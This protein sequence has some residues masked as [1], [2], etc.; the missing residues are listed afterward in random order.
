MTKRDISEWVRDVKSGL[1]PAKYAYI[2]ETYEIGQRLDKEKPQWEITDKKFEVDGRLV[3]EVKAGKDRFL[4]Y[5][6]SGKGAPE[7]K[8]KGQFVP[9]IGFAKNGWF[10]KGRPEGKGLKDYDPWYN[11]KTFKEIAKHLEKNKEKIFYKKP[12]FKSVEKVLKRRIPTYK[13]IEKPKVISRAS[14]IIKRESGD[15]LGISNTLKNIISKP[16]ETLH[17]K[18][19]LK[20]ER[21]EEYNRKGHFKCE[22][23]GQIFPSYAEAVKHWNKVHYNV[24]EHI[25]T[26]TKEVIGKKIPALLPENIRRSI[27]TPV[28]TGVKR[29]VA[30]AGK[31]YSAGWQRAKEGPI[32]GDRTNWICPSCGKS[33][34]FR[35]KVCANNQCP[36]YLERIQYFKSI[37]QD[38]ANVDVRLKRQLNPYQTTEY[39]AE[40]DMERK[41]LSTSARER[42]DTE[43]YVVIMFVIAGIAA[44]F[45][46]P[47]L[48]FPYQL[49]YL[50]AALMGAMPI[51]ILLPDEADILNSLGWNRKGETYEMIEMGARGWLLVPKAL[52]KIVFFGLVIYQFFLIN[53]II[54][55]VIAFIFYFSLDIEFRNSEPYKM[56]ESFFRMVLGGFIAYLFLVAFGTISVGPS[57]AAMAVAFFAT[58][59]VYKKEKEEAKWRISVEITDKFKTAGGYFDK[60]DRFV[61]FPIWMLVALIYSGVLFWTGD[62]TQIMFGLIW[63]VSLIAGM[64]S[65][66]GGRPALGVVMVIVALFAFSS[67]Y[68][69]Q[70][71]QAVFGYYWPQVQSFSETVLGPVEE[72]FYQAQAGMS[73]AWLMLSNPQQYY[74]LQQQ[75]QQA[76]KSVVKSGGTIRSIE[77]SK[78][79]L[80]TTATG[81][82]EPQ[83]DPL[84]GSIELHNEG[85]FEADNIALTISAIWEDPVDP[86]ITMSFDNF[87]RFECSTPYTSN[88]APLCN[89]GATTYPNEIRL[90]SFAFDRDAWGSLADIEPA[91]DGD[92][93]TADMDVYVHGGETVKITA[94][95]EY[96]Y[97]V[98]VS[99]PVEIIDWNRYFDLLQAREITLQEVT[100]QYTGGPVK[101]TIWSQKQPIRSPESGGQA[102]SSLF[103]AS[104]YNEGKGNITTVQS[105]KIKIPTDM[106]NSI[107]DIS[108]LGST[109]YGPGGLSDDSCPITTEGN[110]YVIECEHTWANHPIKPGEYKR[111]SFFIDPKTIS[112]DIINRLLIGSAKYRYAMTDS[113][114]LTIVN[115][116][117]Q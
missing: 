59:P 32:K 103:V 48:G 97:N 9:I 54:T 57:L 68:T 51:Y 12:P 115:N 4:M 38:P 92:E 44:L 28:K 116:P 84:V 75:K 18:R 17:R 113:K 7:Y 30:T 8:K 100:S 35:R 10:L 104:L 21:V 61:W 78:F 50:A 64:S 111:V 106:V 90:A 3:V 39:K 46:P 95:Y 114:S 15:K 70:I 85:E 108:V 27:P 72:M 42:V 76:T 11:S 45:V 79:D 55:L 96:N 62:I 23:C 24:E 82:L 102:E 19:E 83:E 25:G 56:I 5:E 6:S 26:A 66:S 58:L 107:G 117:P 91:D 87:M 29:G 37:G 86:T 60:I 69:G 73:D 33:W 47:L 13:K 99:L 36:Y 52:V 94:D 20:K 14:E 74:L 112:A 89:W 67:A 16:A 109:F 88:S 40:S 93:T 80:F 2:N 65:G 77:L 81:Y 31:A 63:L 49:V 41:K 34:E 22:K 105:F 43:I 1:D 110:Y 53:M 71:G 98:N 101:A